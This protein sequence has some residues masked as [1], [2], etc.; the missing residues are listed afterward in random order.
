MNARLAVSFSTFVVCGLACAHRPTPESIGPG[1]ELAPQNA[2]PSASAPEA[3]LKVIKGDATVEV[4]EV[5]SFL[6]QARAQATG[7]GGSVVSERLSGAGSRASA[8]L[9]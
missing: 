4:D 1:A 8:E 3:D 5:T 9:Q 7:L 6:G 2:E